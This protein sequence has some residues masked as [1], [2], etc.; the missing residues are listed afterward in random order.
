M[1]RQT[2]KSLHLRKYFMSFLHANIL[3]HTFS[4]PAAA[5]LVRFD[6]NIIE[7]VLSFLT[8]KDLLCV[9][10]VSHAWHRGVQMKTWKYSCREKHEFQQ[11]QRATGLDARTIALNLHYLKHPSRASINVS[12]YRKQKRSYLSHLGCFVLIQVK[13]TIG[14]CQ[15]SYQSGLGGPFVEA[16]QPSA[17]TRLLLYVNQVPLHA[18]GDH[19]LI[20]PLPEGIHG[21]HVMWDPN[22]GSPFDFGCQDRL[23]QIEITTSLWR[24]DS[25]KVCRLNLQ[26]IL[27]TDVTP[28]GSARLVCTCHVQTD[29]KG[30]VW[31]LDPL[32]FVIILELYASVSNEVLEEAELDPTNESGWLR[33]NEVPAYEVRH[34]QAVMSYHE[35]TDDEKLGSLLD[36]L[37]WVGCKRH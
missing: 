22:D 30:N 7:N 19:C 14:G 37:E 27:R 23:K 29:S 10:R 34:L 24:T 32:R 17:R 25:W 33:R 16:T 26:R 4:P 18:K 6:E 2:R 20:Q 15:I 28:E 8:T 35:S 12:Q 11:L 9:L 1:P 31:W 3:P 36:G 13:D 21:S 5:D